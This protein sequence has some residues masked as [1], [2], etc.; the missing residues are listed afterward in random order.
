MV[1]LAS[2]TNDDNKNILLNH[3]KK[4]R[5]YCNEIHPIKKIDPFQTHRNS[6]NPPKKQIP[7]ELFQKKTNNLSKETIYGINKS[8][9]SQ[10]E[11]Y[12]PFYNLVFCPDIVQEIFSYKNSI[13]ILEMRRKISFL[14]TPLTSHCFEKN[15]DKMKI[16]SSNQDQLIQ[17]YLKDKYTNSEQPNPKLLREYY[18]YSKAKLSLSKNIEEQHQE[19]SSKIKSL[20]KI[21]NQ[22]YEEDEIFAENNKNVSNLYDWHDDLT[23][24]HT[25]QNNA[26]LKNSFSAQVGIHDFKGIMQ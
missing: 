16:L 8:Q 20:Q 19:K 14:K 23:Q 11:N 6:F 13:N 2:N 26:H 12:Q 1:N 21:E 7:M 18:R 10:F 9:T 22:T 15:L 25:Y 3:S 17:N 5:K 4:I 24:H